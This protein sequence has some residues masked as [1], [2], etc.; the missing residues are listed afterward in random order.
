MQIK[1]IVGGIAAW[2]DCPAVLGS[3]VVDLLLMYHKERGLE[4]WLEIEPILE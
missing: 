4:K 1:S 2:L 3:Q